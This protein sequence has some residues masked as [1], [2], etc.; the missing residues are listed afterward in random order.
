MVIMVVIMVDSIV[1]ASCDNMNNREKDAFRMNSAFILPWHRMQDPAIY[2]WLS[3]VIV[4]KKIDHSLNI[5][6]ACIAN[7]HV[8][9]PDI[10]E[11]YEALEQINDLLK[12]GFVPVPDKNV[13][14]TCSSRPMTPKP[15]KM[16]PAFPEKGLDLF[17]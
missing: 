3:Q 10:L 16:L 9:D 4:P 13:P 6:H 14:L 8:V 1:H 5:P 17:E 2:A 15:Q 12:Q 11:E 7:D